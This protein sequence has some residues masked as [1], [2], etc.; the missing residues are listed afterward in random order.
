MRILALDI[1]SRCGWATNCKGVISVGAWEL[2]SKKEVSEWNK[3]RLTRRRDPRIIRLRDKIVSF[4]GEL[5]CVIFEDL[6]FSSYRKQMQLWSSLRA[7]AWVA[8]DKCNILYEAVNVKVLKKWATGNGNA[9]KP[10]MIAAAQNQ[11]P[12][13]IFDADS[14]DAFHLLTW[15]EAHIKL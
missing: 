14:A 9:D 1:A 13:L 12:D 10:M 6:E 11:R 2:A 3:K 8:C 7:A 4:C 5:D 15:A